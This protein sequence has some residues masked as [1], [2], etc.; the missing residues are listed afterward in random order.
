MNRRSFFGWLTGVVA[1]IAAPLPTMAKPVCFVGARRVRHRAVP[2]F[3][4]S[5]SAY[6]VD[7]EGKWIT[8][9]ENIP[10]AEYKNV[11]SGRIYMKP[12]TAAQLQDITK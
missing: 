5:T 9:G 3:T 10:R 8:I 6:Y 2:V 4:R 7:Y 11:I 1:V 12:M